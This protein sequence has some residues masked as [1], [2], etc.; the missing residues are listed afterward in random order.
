MVT[1]GLIA[2]AGDVAAILPRLRPE[3]RRD[4]GARSCA[5][6]SGSF[7]QN[8][9][10]RFR[11][12]AS[13]S[14]FKQPAQNVKAPPPLFSQGAGCA[15]ISIPSLT[16]GGLPHKREGAERRKALC[17]TPHPVARLTA[18]LSRQRT[19]L[20]VHDADRRASR[21]ST[22][23]FSL[24]LET[25]FW[26]RK[27]PQSLSSLIPQGFSPCVHP[28]HQPVAGRTHVVGPGSDSRGPRR[29]G[30]LGRTRRRRARSTI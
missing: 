13:D 27:E 17:G 8:A 28:L 23:A 16:R 6:T 7:R 3:D 19:G 1:G 26:R 21:R 10:R 30:W 11:A 4:A 12:R 24:D 15:G 25:A 2:A 5:K 18:S 29:P 22:A 9:L 14:H 20:P